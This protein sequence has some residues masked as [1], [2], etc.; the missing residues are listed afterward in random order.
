MT[1][2]RPATACAALLVFLALTIVPPCAAQS[3]QAGQHL[4][5]LPS[6]AF[7]QRAA[8]A[9]GQ[10]TDAFR[11]L[12]FELHFQPLHNFKELHN[13]PSESVFIMLGNPS[14]LSKSNFPKGLRDFVEHGGAVLIATDLKPEGD[15]E[16][17][18]KRLAGVTVAGEKLLCCNRDANDIY[19]MSKYC[20]FVKSLGVSLPRSGSTNPLSMLA[21]VLG[22]GGQ[23]AL[24][25]NPHPEQPDLQRVA[26]NAPSRLKIDGRWLPVGIYQLA[27]L[28]SLCQDEDTVNQPDARDPQRE[29]PLFAIGGTVG[30][31]RVIVLADHSLFINRMVLP[32]DTDNLEFAVNCLHW[33]RGGIST[34]M[35]A[36]RAASLKQLA[37]Q[38]NKAL[39]WDDGDIRRNFEVPLKKVPIKPA[40]VSEPAIVAAVD[41]TLA[42]MEDNDY[43]NRQILD[44]MD[45]LPG[46]RKRV[47]RYAVYLLTVAAFLFLG[48]RF[49]WQSRHRPEAT[50]PGLAEAISQH[51][52]KRSLLDQRRRALLRSGNVWEIVHRLARDYFDSAGVPLTGAAPRVEM[53]HGNRWQ[54]WRLNRRVAR[55][56]K[57]ARAGAPR[58]IPPSA[59]K[60][61]LR[62]LEALK[63]ALQDGKIRLT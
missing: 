60:R 22:A 20:P 5:Q 57:L 33:L 38:R 1:R 18:L 11:R 10:Q 25:R 50:V 13:N 51:E 12:L 24:F 3:P 6:E 59:L 42:R 23:P 44:S 45:S 48:Y 8:R 47:L 62:E 19:D 31:G 34:P 29:K 36:L 56:W 16:D 17:N 37:G 15:A 53:T 52:P 55:L 46:G 9:Y 39:F 58:V 21:A 2:C 7:K 54:R 49:L 4:K 40:P 61:W 63:S 26:T 14:C 27:V 32:R 43:F 28:P 41:K 35:E 30:K